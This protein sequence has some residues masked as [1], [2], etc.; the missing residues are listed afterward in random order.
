MRLIWRLKDEER[1]PTD[2]FLLEQIH[3]TVDEASRIQTRSEREGGA[4]VHSLLILPTLTA[5]RHILRM[6]SSEAA[7][8]ALEGV[9][10]ALQRGD[11]I[12]DLDEY[13]EGHGMPR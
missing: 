2:D 5:P 7:L 1:D 12:F 13:L 4:T 11:A 8:K 9:S 6:P 10:D 3:V